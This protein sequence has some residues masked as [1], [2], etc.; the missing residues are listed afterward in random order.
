MLKAVVACTLLLLFGVASGSRAAERLVTPP[1]P[2]PPV[3]REAFAK[4]QGV[5][6]VREQIPPDQKLGAHRDILSAQGLLKQPGL[7]AD[8]LLSNMFAASGASCERVRVNG[9]TIRQEGGYRVA[10]GQLYCSREK[11]AATCAAMMLKVIE[12]T[13]AIYV[14]NRE[15]RTPPSA[16]AGVQDFGAG[17]AAQAKAA[18]FMNAMATAN[19]YLEKS[20][21]L[22]GNRSGD[23]RCAGPK[24]R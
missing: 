14:I 12:G 13:D 16:V 1:Y 5:Q 23:V 8:R 21:Y 18:A 20:V 4:S 3:W 15:F 24:P 19:T 2:G 11:G 9:P 10:Y 22:C 7:T 17:P 6:F